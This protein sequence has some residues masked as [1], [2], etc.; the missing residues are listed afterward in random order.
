MVNLLFIHGAWH[1]SGCWYKVINSELLSNYKVHALDNPMNGFNTQYSAEN[2]EQYTSE[3]Q[4]LLK[5][6]NE[7]FIIIAHSM[8]GSIASFIA[9]KFPKKI[10]KI[11]YVA[12]SM[13]AKNKCALDYFMEEYY[14]NFIKELELENLVIPDSQGQFIKLNIFE[15]EKIIKLFYNQSPKLDIGIALKNLSELSSGIPFAHKHNYC[16]EFYPIKKVY[17]ECT[18]DNAMPISMQREMQSNFS[19]IKTYTLNTD[20]SPF[21]SKNKELSKII[22]KEIENKEV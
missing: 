2:F 16:E 1:W 18:N 3:I 11:I 21:F 8:G 4:N 13:C 6:T 12:A 22:K 20:H 19:D 10:E 5:T 14:F 7:K 17:V 9:N 15:K